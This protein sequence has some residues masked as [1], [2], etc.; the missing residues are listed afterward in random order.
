MSSATRRACTASSCTP[1]SRPPPHGAS[2]RRRAS[3]RDAVTTRSSAREASSAFDGEGA[4]RRRRA[5]FAGDG[6]GVGRRSQRVR[7]LLSELSE[8][9]LVDTLART[10]MNT[11]SPVTPA[12]ALLLV[13]C[14][15]NGARDASV[16]GHDRSADRADADAARESAQYDPAASRTLINCPA[17]PRGTAA[18]IP[19]W[20]TDVNPT[21][22]HLRRARALRKLADDHRAA[23]KA[24]RD[25]EAAA[26]AGIPL[27]DRDRSP[28]Q[29]DGDLVGVQELRRP[30]SIFTLWMQRPGGATFTLRAVPGLTR[31][32]LQRLVTCHIARNASTGYSLAGMEACPLAVKG[33]VATVESPGPGVFFVHVSA[34]E[35]AA[36]AEVW[37]RAQMLA[38]TIP[39]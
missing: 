20:T 21:E 27:P 1:S 33:A 8:R 36:S 2:S 11:R 35:A 9:A 18:G 10:V 17:G 38:E 16:A 19:C 34:E 32:Y 6:P 7:G 15:G 13:A 29:H 24:L 31:E 14:G 39:R 3:A 26:C 30:G 4:R 37:K 25:V 23:S 22:D 28:L 12:I 5:P